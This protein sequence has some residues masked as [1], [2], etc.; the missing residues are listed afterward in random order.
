MAER[1]RERKKDAP[2][3][4]KGRVLAFKRRPVPRRSAEPRRWVRD[5]SRSTDVPF[6]RQAVALGQIAE[7]SKLEQTMKGIAGV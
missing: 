2:D 4:R 5:I 6:E 7:S 3:D 1:E